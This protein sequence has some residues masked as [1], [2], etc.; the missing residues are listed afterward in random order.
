MFLLCLWVK[1]KTKNKWTNLRTLVNHSENN[2]KYNLAP[3]G[4]A[5]AIWVFKKSHGFEETKHYE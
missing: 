4:N 3:N 5:L 2:K 1:N